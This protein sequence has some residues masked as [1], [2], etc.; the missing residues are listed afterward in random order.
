M[1]MTHMFSFSSN[2]ASLGSIDA[3][4]M[5]CVGGGGVVSSQQLF[6]TWI[7]VIYANSIGR[8]EAERTGKHCSEKVE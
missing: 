1:G 4:L 5:A 3:V 2:S 6:C 7:N 8:K